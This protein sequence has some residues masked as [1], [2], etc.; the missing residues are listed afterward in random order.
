MTYSISSIVQC[1]MGQTEGEEILP[2]R[3]VQMTRPI[4][5]LHQ[6]FFFFF[7][8]NTVAYYCKAMYKKKKKKPGCGFSPLLFLP[9]L[10][11]QKLK[12]VQSLIFLKKKI[13]CNASLRKIQGS[14]HHLE[15]FA[16]ALSCHCKQ[17]AC[18]P[19]GE[20]LWERKGD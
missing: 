7:P 5:L 8:S 19:R 10:Y 20:A 13:L 6:R 17:Q 3:L 12:V 4:V 1:M 9:S 16:P 11:T 14:A 2:R 15:L 18:W